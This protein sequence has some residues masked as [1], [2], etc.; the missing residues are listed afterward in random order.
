MC[1]EVSVNSPGIRGVSNVDPQCM[2]YF[3]ETT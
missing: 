2:L 3:T 1:S